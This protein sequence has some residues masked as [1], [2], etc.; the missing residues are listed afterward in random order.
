M[1]C[2]NRAM[3]GWMR[4]DRCLQLKK[5]DLVHKFKKYGTLTMHLFNIFL[6]LI[7]CLC[8]CVR[9]SSNV[10][11]IPFSHKHIKHDK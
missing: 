6:G 2:F 5:R 3:K 1:A 9:A 11:L 8:A 7:W 4:K 10:I